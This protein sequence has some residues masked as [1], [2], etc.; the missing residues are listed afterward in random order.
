M[1]SSDSD[2]KVQRERRR[3]IGSP[4]ESLISDWTHSVLLIC[5]T[6]AAFLQLSRLKEGS[7]IGERHVN[8]RFI[9]LYQNDYITPRAKRHGLGTLQCCGLSERDVGSRD[10]EARTVFIHSRFPSRD[11]TPS[12]RLSIAIN[13]YSSNN[14]DID[15][16]QLPL[17]YLSRPSRPFPSTTAAYLEWL[18]IAHAANDDYILLENLALG[19]EIVDATYGN[20]RKA[21]GRECELESRQGMKTPKG[22]GSEHHYPALATPRR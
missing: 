8:C 19:F 13:I 21:Q 20:L 4:A 5:I 15:L 1:I 2:S 9:S 22:P 12:I 17:S 7:A 6:T 11:V 14:Y 3:E 16:S 18:L 10:E